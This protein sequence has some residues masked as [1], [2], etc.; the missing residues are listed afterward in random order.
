MFWG[1]ELVQR[2]EF[3]WIG[4]IMRICSFYEAVVIRLAGMWCGLSE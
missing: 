1:N 3:S 4:K 2:K